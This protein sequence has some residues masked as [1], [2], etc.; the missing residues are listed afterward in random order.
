MRLVRR[1]LIMQCPVRHGRLWLKE[2]DLHE[3][4]GGRDRRSQRLS[5]FRSQDVQAQ[6]DVG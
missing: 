6:V 2:L 4:R 3:D 1:E 5:A